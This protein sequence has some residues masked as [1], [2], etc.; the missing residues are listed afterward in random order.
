ML[1]GSLWTWCARVTAVV[2]LSL[3][4]TGCSSNVNKKAFDSC[5]PRSV[6]IV[7]GHDLHSVSQSASQ[8]FLIMALFGVVG[9]VVNETS[10]DKPAVQNNAQV[11]GVLTDRAVSALKEKGYS[12]CVLQCREIEYNTFENGGG[13]ARDFDRLVQKYDIASAMEQVDAVLFIEA[14]FEFRFVRPRE[15]EEIALDKVQTKVAEMKLHL[16][17]RETKQ[18]LFKRLSM[19]ADTRDFNR[20][21]GK[22]IELSKVPPVSR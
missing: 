19:L 4:C 22:L 7:L 16:F 11:N 9:A 1:S 8:E 12:T 18:C 20:V 21:S 5:R 3:V 14:F 2:A 13:K 15:G 6:G 10:L 17:D